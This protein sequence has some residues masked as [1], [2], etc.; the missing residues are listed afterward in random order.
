MAYCIVLKFSSRGSRA[1]WK[2]K[3]MMRI[4]STAGSARNRSQ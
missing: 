4:T 2:P 3:L 1:R